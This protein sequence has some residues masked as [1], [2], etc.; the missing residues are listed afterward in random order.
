[1]SLESQ[2]FES[3]NAAEN[4]GEYLS[5]VTGCDYFVMNFGSSHWLVPYTTE[6]TQSAEELRHV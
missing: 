2:V 5:A 1:M 3:E 4:Y 6:A